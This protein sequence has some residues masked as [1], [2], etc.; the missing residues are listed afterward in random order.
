MSGASRGTMMVPLDFLCTRLGRCDLLFEREGLSPSLRPNEFVELESGKSVSWV[1]KGPSVLVAIG[2]AAV[3][4]VASCCRVD[5]IIDDRS[6]EGLGIVKVWKESTLWPVEVTAKKSKRR[7]LRT[8]QSLMVSKTIQ[9]HSLARRNGRTVTTVRD[10]IRGMPKGGGRPGFFLVGS[11]DLPSRS[12]RRAATSMTI[13]A[14]TTHHPPPKPPGKVTARDKTEPVALRLCHG[15]A[16][17]TP[18]ETN[19]DILKGL[20]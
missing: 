19:R 8:L 20:R 12:G 10:S 14:P 1:G 4:S 13:L 2:S 9:R 18:K 17:L 16:P 3:G 15:T 5:I 11:E 7:D 6:E